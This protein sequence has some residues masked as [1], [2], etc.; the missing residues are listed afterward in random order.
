MANLNL[1]DKIKKSNLQR[2]LYVR[3]AQIDMKARAA[4]AKAPRKTRAK[5][6]P[7]ER[8]WAHAYLKHVA[9][10][11]G[12]P[13]IGARESMQAMGRYFG[14]EIPVEKAGAGRSKVAIDLANT[15]QAKTGINLPR[16]Q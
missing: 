6:D 4:A 14:I 15:I 10:V 9:E 3:N 13:Y 1:S 7:K 16:H 12:L 8:S 11:K 2:G 5:M